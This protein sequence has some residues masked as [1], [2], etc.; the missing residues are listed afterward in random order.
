MRGKGRAKDK[1][2]GKGK[3]AGAGE[4]GVV[5]SGEGVLA[6]R[7]P[8]GSTGSSA[9]ASTD[10][11]GSAESGARGSSSGVVRFSVRP[12]TG[13]D[14]GAV[15][16]LLDAALLPTDGVADHFPVGY[17]VAVAGDR[18]VGA[19]GIEVYGEYGLLRSAVVSE[20]WR[21]RGVGEALTWDRI[22]WSRGRG[23][24]ALYLVT[25]TAPSFFA[26]FGFDPVARDAVPVLVRGSAQFT[27]QCPSTAIVMALALGSPAGTAD[28]IEAVGAPGVDSAPPSRSGLTQ[29]RRSFPGETNQ[30]ATIV[31]EK[32][33]EAARRAAAGQVAS[34]CGGAPAV[35]GEH[36]A[37]C[38][39][40]CR[41]STG[42]PITGGLYAA[43][44]L[45]GLP[46]EAVLASLGCG[47][48][49]ALA[50]LSPGEVVL[51]LGSGGGID[52]LLSAKRVGPNGRA[53]GIDMTDEMLELARANQRRSGV[54]NAEFLK[55][56]IENV[57]LPDASVDVI[58]SNCV[59]N[60]SSDKRRVVREAFRVLRPGGRVAVSDIV[61]RGAVPEAIRRSVEMWIGC[62]AGALEEREYRELL[63][64][65]GFADIEIEPTR[66]YSI[67]DARAFLDGAGLDPA[68]AAAADSR[69]M[70]AFVRAR[71]PAAG[72][73]VTAHA[74]RSGEA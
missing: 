47:N 21:G 43:E 4:A 35:H 55:G 52:V 46:A 9:G 26:R 53:Y 40:G 24:H 34:C 3:F 8:L 63:A 10:S 25:M 1:G 59:I 29:L 64:D 38:G 5:A 71:K 54:T 27:S 56:E 36:A 42:D 32:Y 41:S 51:D 2:R 48:P 28:G 68:L 60:L 66:I 30:L 18:V 61:V 31:R 69:F 17:S 19:E 44:E 72:A 50:S 73:D 45:R 65:V 67:E 12:A 16:A 33:G 14:L 6:E 37:D 13:A 58:I 49:A 11:V 39:C 62:V 15:R 22:G 74:N 70:S 57:P 20:A 23:L 7:N